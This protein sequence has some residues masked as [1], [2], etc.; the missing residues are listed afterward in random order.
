MTYD[1]LRTSR[2]HVVRQ[3]L[4]TVRIIHASQKKIIFGARRA[5]TNCFTCSIKPAYARQFK[6]FLRT[7]MRLKARD[8][9]SKHIKLDTLFACAM[10]EVH[11]S[12]AFNGQCKSLP[13]AYAHRD[14]RTAPPSR[15][16]SCHG[17]KWQASVDQ[18]SSDDL[19]RVPSRTLPSEPFPK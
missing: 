18:L 13:D 6:I 15:A 8:P 4:R 12:D 17:E 5:R 16:N 7:T 19:T 14:Q 2:S 1:S 9:R 11:A 3:Q 10:C